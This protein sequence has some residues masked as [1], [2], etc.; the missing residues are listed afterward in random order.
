MV[1]RT[2]HVIG[3]W[4]TSCVV[5]G[6]WV[7]GGIAGRQNTTYGIVIRSTYVIAVLNSPIFAKK[8]T[9]LKQVG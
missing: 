5:I 4:K 6:P 2:N 9:I 3:Y 7:E 8:Q 1:K